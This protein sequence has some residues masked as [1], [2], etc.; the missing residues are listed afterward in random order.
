MTLLIRAAGRTPQD[1]GVLGRGEPGGHKC[2]GG[3]ERPD[4]RR[5]RARAA[6]FDRLRR[7]PTRPPAIK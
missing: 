7:R 5:R 3:Q 2:H 6:P 1:S 4:A